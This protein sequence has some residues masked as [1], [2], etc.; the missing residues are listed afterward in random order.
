MTKE[1]MLKRMEELE[2]KRFMLAMKDRWDSSDYDRDNKLFN[3][4]LE[5]KKKV[6]EM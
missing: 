1:E 3:E 5:L 6:A 4:W 2:G